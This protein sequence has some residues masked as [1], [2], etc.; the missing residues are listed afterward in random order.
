MHSRH[1]LTK[2]LRLFFFPVCVHV[3]IYLHGICKRLFET[4]NTIPNMYV[5]CVRT[6]DHICEYA[7][8]HTYSMHIFWQ[9]KP[10]AGSSPI[11]CL[12]PSV[13]CQSQTSNTR[14]SPKLF[15]R[16]KMV[17]NGGR[18]VMDNAVKLLVTS[19]NSGGGASFLSSSIRSRL[20]RV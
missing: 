17:E 18:S 16:W 5:F 13:L 19:D 15:E 6:H 12:F 11:V 9:T 20:P 7:N 14:L 4:N 8:I 1:L 3:I 10:H 2:Y